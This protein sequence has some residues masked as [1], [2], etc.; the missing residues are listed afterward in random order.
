MDI[1]PIIRTQPFTCLTGV[2]I[3]SVLSNGDI[4]VCPDVERRPE[5]IQGNIRKERFIDVWEKKFKIY[6]KLNR[7]INEKCKKCKDW[8]LCG[9]DAFHT[10]DFDHNEPRFCHLKNLN[11]PKEK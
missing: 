4:F 11:R 6:R 2:T 5:L 1:E 3:G 9:G 8:K 10:W 7:T